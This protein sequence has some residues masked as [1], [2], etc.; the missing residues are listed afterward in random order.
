MH[1]A[2]LL[3]ECAG[4]ASR[5]LWAAV[6]LEAIG[7]PVTVNTS[8]RWLTRILAVGSPS[9]EAA[10][11]HPE[12]RSATTSQ[13]LPA[14][15]K[16]SADIVSKTRDGSGSLSIGSFCCDGRYLRHAEH[17]VTVSW[18]CWLIPGQ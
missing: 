5:E 7:A 2:P 14:C 3:Q 16:K 4:V 10:M 1:H 9:M 6:G 11:G 8:L 15:E 18:T 13:D 17:A 12:R